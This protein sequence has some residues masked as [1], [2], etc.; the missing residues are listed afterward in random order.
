MRGPALDGPIRG[1]NPCL[2][3]TRPHKKPGCHDHCDDRDIWLS[4]LKTV[5]DNRRRY[6]EMR[7]VGWRKKK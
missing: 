5:N 3:C 7:D 2:G 1:D 6:Y 4:K